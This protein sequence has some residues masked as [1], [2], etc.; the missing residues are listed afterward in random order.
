MRATGEL[1]ARVPLQQAGL[2]LYAAG[3]RL[4]D[5][6]D[7]DRL[8]SLQVGEPHVQESLAAQRVQQEPVLRH[9]Q[10]DRHRVGQQRLHPQAEHHVGD[11]LAVESVEGR[12]GRAE[13]AFVVREGARSAAL[14]DRQHVLPGYLGMGRLGVE[15]L[16][17]E[18]DLGALLVGEIEEAVLDVGDADVARAEVMDRIRSLR[19]HLREVARGE[20]VVLYLLRKLEELT[21]L[22]SHDLLAPDVALLNS[23]PHHS[24]AVALPAAVV[25]PDCHP[26]P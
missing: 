11:R 19:P 2:G 13:L 3:E 4:P 21:A 9:R 5:R 24:A 17:D 22:D 6:V 23:L 12:I 18:L 25:D 7:P 1:A 8:L 20:Q 26:W 10:Q 14:A 15:G 16:G